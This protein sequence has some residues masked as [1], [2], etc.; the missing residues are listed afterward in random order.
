MVLALLASFTQAKLDWNLESTFLQ[1]LQQQTE[2]VDHHKISEEL[3]QAHI[4][5]TWVAEGTCS[6]K[7]VD[8]RDEEEFCVATSTCEQATWRRAFDRHSAEEVTLH[9]YKIPM[10]MSHCEVWGGMNRCDGT[11][12]D[13]DH[14]C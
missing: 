2:E 9:D 10:S 1:H 12:C 3:Q 13:E 6:T 8:I 4:Y 7:C 11:L 14:E 5:P